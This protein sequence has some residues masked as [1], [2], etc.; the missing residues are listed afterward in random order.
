M[1][2]LLILVATRNLP[3]LQLP[4][5]WDS[6]TMAASVEQMQQ[7]GFHPILPESWDYGHPVLLMELM[8][9]ATRVWGQTVEIPHL[10]ILSFAFLAVYY[11]CRVGQVLYGSKAGITAAFLLAFY[12]L[13]WAQSTFVYLDLPAAALAIMAV[14]YALRAQ[15]GRYLLCAVAA[16]MTKETASFVLLGLLGFLAVETQRQSLGPRLRR[17]GVYSLPLWV[18]AGWFGYHL[19]VTGW[20]STPL[21][22]GWL[23]LDHWQP[24]QTATGDWVQA[25]FGRRGIVTSFV[26]I[27]PTYFGTVFL[28]GIL[29]LLIVRAA[30]AL[31]SLAVL[32]E[33]PFRWDAVRRALGTQPFLRPWGSPSRL[34]LLALPILLQAAFMAVTTDRQRYLLPEY[35]L[36]FILAAQAIH[37]IF[38]HGPRATVLTASLGIMFTGFSLGGANLVG[39]SKWLGSTQADLDSPATLRYI[40][41]VET[42][43][44]ASAF[45]ESEFPHSRVL[46]T[47]PQYLELGLPS[48]GYVTR[49]I[50]IVAHPISPQLETKITEMGGRVIADPA[51]L[52]LDDFDLVYYSDHTPGNELL[53][54]VVQRF[55]LP[56]VAAFGNN[57]MQAR[58][59][60]NPWHLRLPGT[61]AP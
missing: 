38:P 19:Q 58:I 4:P 24:G 23:A 7:N 36:F 26:K 15:T 51:A 31:P 11:T 13:F 1:A 43:Q 45:L 55:G 42:H 25:V 49:P 40:G 35:P 8:A 61:A 28:T 22:M 39:D 60:A 17:L 44:A 48:L 46:T 33:R 20:I 32:R 3:F 59:Y 54:E 34:I 9:L 52:T 30:V 47:W 50:Q 18:L 5:F 10:I 57:G 27:L 29:T 6:I 14:Y 41:F 16:V 37:S 12:P 56:P 2:A 21:N 53:Q